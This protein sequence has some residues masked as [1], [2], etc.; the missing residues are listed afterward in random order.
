MHVKEREAERDDR[1]YKHTHTHLIFS[2][3]DSCRIFMGIL[4]GLW[5]GR[6][7]MLADLWS[8]IIQ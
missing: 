4:I 3:R 2:I 7:R 5:A 6:Q 8:N 1:F